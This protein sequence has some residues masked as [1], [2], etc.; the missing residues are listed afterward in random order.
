LV[1]LL[2]EVNQITNDASVAAVEESSG[3]TSVTGTSSTTDSMNV[4]INVSWEIVVDDMSDIGDIQATFT[5]LADDSE[6]FETEKKIP[7]ILV[8]LK[9]S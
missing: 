3:D 1:S 7:K 4:V 9:S 5:E 2:Q 8:T 6:M